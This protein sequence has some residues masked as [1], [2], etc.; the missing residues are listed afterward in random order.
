[1]GLERDYQI[2][3]PSKQFIAQAPYSILRPTEEIAKL[4]PNFITGFTDAEGSFTVTIYPDNLVKTGIRVNAGFK[5]GLNERDLDLLTKI[6]KFF[7]EIG[8]IYYN[9]ALKSWT[10]TVANVR[11]LENVIIPHF[12]E[13]P[14]LTQKAADFKLFVKIVQKIEG[15]R[16]SK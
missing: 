13:Y 4:N 16:S 3:I 15:R 10:Y 9:T 7:G 11:D 14:L 1:M 2:E 5:I 6:Q 8:K 12:I